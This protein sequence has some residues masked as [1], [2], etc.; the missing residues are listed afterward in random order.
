MR[1]NRHLEFKVQ[2]SQWLTKKLSVHAECARLTSTATSM[3]KRPCSPYRSM[4]RIAAKHFGYRHRKHE[5]CNRAL[6]P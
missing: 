2:P 3:T 1:E 4:L 5:R 6:T